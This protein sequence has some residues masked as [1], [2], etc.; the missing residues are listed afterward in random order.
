LRSTNNNNKDEPGHAVIYF[1]G[2]VQDIP[3]VM[4][5]N[6]DTKG[7]VKFNLDNTAMILRE[8]FPRSYIVVVRPVRWLKVSFF[9]FTFENVIIKFLFVFR[10][11]FTTF[12]CFDNFVR[13]NNVGI[14]DHTPMHFAL[15]HLEEYVG[16]RL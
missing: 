12:S 2:D 1:G 13:G 10:M 5:E 6:R 8:A 15:Q 3:E 4:E 7:Y 11:E 14:P 16:K 9:K